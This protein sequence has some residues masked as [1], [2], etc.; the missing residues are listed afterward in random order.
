VS[1]D[2]AP[3]R[4]EGAGLTLIG[5]E[6]MQSNAHRARLGAALAA[7]L[8][9][10]GAAAAQGLAGDDGRPLAPG[11]QAPEWIAPALTGEGE[12]G[13][14]QPSGL[15]TNPGWAS[16]SGFEFRGR[17]HP[18]AFTT[19]DSTGA[20]WCTGGS[21]RFAEARLDLPH[22]VRLEF[23]RMWGFKQQPNPDLT[24][25]LFESCL[26]NLSAGSPQTTNIAEV[27]GG[28]ATGEF[29]AVTGLAEPPLTDT[30]NCTYWARVRFDE[31]CVAGGQ[32]TLRKVRV[33]YRPE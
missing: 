15:I 3:T 2:V 26:P 11:G 21:E 9:A 14:A 8:L 27:S 4:T 24:V 5:E 16:V 30:R 23:L 25:F 17:S 31:G 33:Q 22:N 20:L 7:G 12:P 10:A 1:V 28:V 6:P 13:Q 18:F 29:S 32:L 19:S